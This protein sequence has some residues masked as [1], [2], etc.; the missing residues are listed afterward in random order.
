MYDREPTPA[1]QKV[2]ITSTVQ[3]TKCIFPQDD[4]TAD[5]LHLPI[6][7]SEEKL[8]STWT[9][10]LCNRTKLHDEQRNARI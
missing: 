6:A 3:N 2:V 8:K 9:R 5:V 1:K 7:S 10:T 4:R